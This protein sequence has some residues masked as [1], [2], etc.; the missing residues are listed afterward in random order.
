M[1]NRHS[2]IVEK[3][4]ELVQHSRNGCEHLCVN[5]LDVH[6][7]LRVLERMKSNETIYGLLH[8]VREFGQ[9]L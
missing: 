8:H 9:I 7:S 4:D 1:L 5:G 6:V 2:V 3:R